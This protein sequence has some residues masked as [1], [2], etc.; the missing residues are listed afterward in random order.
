MDLKFCPECKG[1]LV[2]KR[3]EKNWFVR[4]EKC[5]FLCKVKNKP[6]IDEEEIEHEE[7][8]KGIAKEQN[9]FANYKHKC[10]KCRYEK[11]ELINLGAQY[12]DENELVMIRCGK[13]GFTER[14]EKNSS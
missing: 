2:P 14:I 7:R 11:G 9:S 4:C 1:I 13:C 5:G 8:G 6:L 12:S 3:I 10:K